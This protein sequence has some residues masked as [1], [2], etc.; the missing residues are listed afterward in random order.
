MRGIPVGRQFASGSS[1]D[2]LA[3]II[4]SASGKRGIVSP[5][6]R[7]WARSATGPP[8]FHTPDKSALPLGR[9]G[10][11]PVGVGRPRCCAVDDDS[12]I[13]ANTTAREDRITKR[14]ATEDLLSSTD[15]S[16]DSVRRYPEI[17]KT[18]A[19]RQQG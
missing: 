7:P 6:A 11:G 3:C 18:R 19:S 15:S 9:R 10:A 13:T 16:A 14:F 17:R 5:F 8:P 12:D 4:F 2:C 1:L